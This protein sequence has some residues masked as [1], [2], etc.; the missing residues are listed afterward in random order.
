MQTPTAVLV[1][2]VPE[3]V[4]LEA[5]L[6]TQTRRARQISPLTDRPPGRIRA[7]VTERSDR[8]GWNLHGE[9]MHEACYRGLENAVSCGA[10]DRG[11]H[12]K[13]KRARRIMLLAIR[14]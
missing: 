5:T 11:L 4:K 8:K 2:I 1:F 13:G 3:P 14:H 9:I 7:L 6:A 12:C 10:S